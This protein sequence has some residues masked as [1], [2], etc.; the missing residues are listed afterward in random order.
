M[1]LR[2]GLSRNQLWGDFGQG[3]P[4]ESRER[5]QL[6]WSAIADYVEVIKCTIKGTYDKRFQKYFDQASRGAFYSL[7]FW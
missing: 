3:V 5:A 4:M 7:Q 1:Q 2:G 6:L